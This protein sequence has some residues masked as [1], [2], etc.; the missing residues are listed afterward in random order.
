MK[1][2]CNNVTEMMEIWVA[3]IVRFRTICRKLLLMWCLSDANQ[4]TLR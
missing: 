1:K 3:S 2:L 4:Y